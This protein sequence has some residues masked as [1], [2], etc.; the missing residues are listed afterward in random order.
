MNSQLFRIRLAEKEQQEEEHRQLQSVYGFIPT[1]Q[2]TRQHLNLI[3]REQKKFWK[4]VFSGLT[5]EIKLDY[6]LWKP[7]LSHP[8]FP[9]FQLQGF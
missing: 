1:Q 8:V 3:I 7:K 5:Q 9:L 4:V 2:G 6:L